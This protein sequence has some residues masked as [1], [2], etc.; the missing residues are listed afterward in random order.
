MKQ[1]T[2]DIAP[3]AAPTLDNFVPGRN[4]EAVVALYAF[5]N[6]AS[7]EQFIYVWGDIGCGRTHLLNAVAIMGRTRGVSIQWF[8]ANKGVAEVWAQSIWL[9]DDVH[10]L[11]GDAQIQLFNLHNRLRAE[12]GAL[13]VAGDAAPAQLSLRADLVTRLASGLVY[14][15]KGLDDAEKA[16]ALTTHAHS[17]GIRL[18]REVT[19]YLLRHARRDLPSLLALLEA[20]DRYSLETKRAV[21]VPLVRELLSS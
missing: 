2:L 18:S 4:A 19:D 21:T 6:G 17:R 10:R 11:D 3:P 16:A 13:L 7:S 8:D 9:V 12:G 5:A 15:L 14:H 20:L 1:L